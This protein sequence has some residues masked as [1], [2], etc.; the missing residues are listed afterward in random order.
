MRYRFFTADVFTD[1]V[2][3]G[4][5]LAVLPEAEGLDTRRMQ[6][7]AREFN[8]SETAFVLPPGDPAHTRRV[9]IFTPA[10]EL[11]FAGHP[12]VGTA[13]VLAAIG[14][15]PLTGE[16]TRVVF[17]EGVGPV[18][19]TVRAAGG[20][21]AFA[22][23]SVAKLPEFGPEPPAPAAVADA[24][25]LDVADLADGGAGVQAVSCGVPILFVPVPDRGALRRARV[26]R[27]AWERVLAPSWAPQVFVFTPDAERPGSDLRARVFAPMLGVEEDPAT[28]AAAAALGGYL[29]VRADGGDGTL[30][31]VV[32]Q[33]FEMGRPSILEVE[34]DRRGGAVTAVR[35]GGASVMVGEGG[36]EV[37]DS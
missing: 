11:P 21:P 13:F 7:V 15:V 35:V 6:L 2:F 8:L 19:V 12:T 30:R 10:A 1:R 26:N 32:E 3:G 18:P 27:A 25:S 33:G 24:L 5:P 37:P 9:R 23:L 16:E 20:R 34:A 22:Q 4:N 28:G 29:G 17:E 36:I 14:A 31:W